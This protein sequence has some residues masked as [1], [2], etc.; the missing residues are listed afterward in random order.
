VSLPDVPAPA[1]A[2]LGPG[3]QAGRVA[4]KGAEVGRAALIIVPIVLGVYALIDCLTSDR[5]RIR[6]LAKGWW[7]VVVVLLPLV[8]P[9]AWLVAG[10]P[11]ARP[12][13]TRR[14][15]V[16][17][18]P[19]DDPNF[20]RTIR[21]LDE[22]HEALLE[23]WERDKRRREGAGGTPPPGPPPAPPGGA[24]GTPPAGRAGPPAPAGD[25]PAAPGR[26]GP[27]VASGPSHEGTTPEATP[28]DRDR[29]DD[30]TAV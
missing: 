27:P 10:R 30:G 22:E 21:T 28:P 16:A 13:P 14:P 29:D 2:K 24:A 20:L 1:S 12:R 9:L 26:E 15:P 6:G 17:L 19:D 18:A 23:Q 11:R 4:S 3:R 5:R 25:D 8:G 7:V